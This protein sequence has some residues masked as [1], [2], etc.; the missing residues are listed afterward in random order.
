MEKVRLDYIQQAKALTGS[1]DI[2]VIIDAAKQLENYITNPKLEWLPSNPVDFLSYV[3]IIHPLRGPI[4]LDAHDFQ[5]NLIWKM[6][7][8]LVQR[9][10]SPFIHVAS[11]QI[12]IST[13]L[14]ALVLWF[15]QSSRHQKIV[16]LSNRMAECFDIGDRMRTML[17]AL[18]HTFGSAQSTRQGVKFNNGS[19][20]VFGAANSLKS[21]AAMEGANLVIIDNAAWISYHNDASYEKAIDEAVKTG[22]RVIVNSCANVPKGI[23]YELWKKTD[24]AFKTSTRWDENKLRDREWGEHYKQQLGQEAFDREFNCLFTSRD[25]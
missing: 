19:E 3:K 6:Y 16:F 23:F 15:A 10:P 24:P 25:E 7:R 9:E 1:N 4:L 22:T 14:S 21:I 12:G 11:R 8:Y 5:K 13:L 20:I 2:A 18:P 17:D